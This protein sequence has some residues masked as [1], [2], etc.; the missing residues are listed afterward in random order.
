MKTMKK[1]I[2][3]A[4]L[5]GTTISCEDFEGWNVDTKNPAEVPAS[6]LVT[7]AQRTIFLR[8]SASNVNYNIFKQLAQ[9]WTA[10]TY[11]DEANYD[12]RQRDLSGTFFIYMYR[13]VLSDLEEAKKI[14]VDRPLVEPT[15]TA[16]MKANQIAII[17]LLQVYTYHVIVDTYGDVPYTE[18]LQGVD[19]LLP[20]Y[21]DD[22]TIYTDLFAR[23][24][25]ALANLTDAD[26]FGDS[27]LIY[28]GDTSNWVKFANS[29]KLRMAVRISDVD[30]GLASSKASEA[31]DSGV[32][33][34]E[35]DNASFPF[36]GGPPNANP[37]WSDLVES[38]RSD[39]IVANTFVDII[40]PLNDPRTTVF[41]D[42]NGPF[43][44]EEDEDAD[45]IYVDYLGGPYGANN[46]YSNYTHAGDP[47]H[48][49]DLEGI[50][51]SYEE[52]EFLLA[53]AVARGLVAGDAEMHYN[54]AI[55]A[56]ITYW[57]GSTSGVADYIAQSAVKYDADNWKKSIGTQKWIALYTKGF[58]AW[59]SWRLLDYPAM[60]T[61]D[62]SGLPVPRRYLYGNDDAQ[63][64]GAN[65]DAASAAM[66]GD[67]L[68]SRV[69]WDITGQGN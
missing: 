12:L 15:Y 47:F 63:I 66:G 46:P 59:S 9:H 58:E 10:T 22:T 25:A 4:I 14:T 8:M 43:N 26:S 64:N 7:S 53:E 27:D 1:L 44:I 69:F 2:L 21:D 3:L 36:E 60:N 18:A 20:K 45:P 51:L 54:N 40:V 32:F 48:K 65:Y 13:D 42:N 30:N 33:E 29:L 55:T 5:I 24:D 38:G 52:V 39:I 11:T 35:L 68:D 62:E 16:A 49:A 37:M 31:I 28:G 41:M 34:S 56:S 6:F 57:T 23:I 61:A 50:I 67:A 17:E 19:N